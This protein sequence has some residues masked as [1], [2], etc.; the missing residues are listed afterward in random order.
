MSMV[1]ANSHRTQIARALNANN[2][3]GPAGLTV[4]KKR[5]KTDVQIVRR[6]YT[7][8]ESDILIGEIWIRSRR[9]LTGKSRRLVSGRTDKKANLSNGRTHG[10]HISHGEMY[11]IYTRVPTSFL[12]ST[13]AMKAQRSA[14]V[15]RE[16][17]SETRSEKKKLGV[18]KLGVI[19][20]SRSEPSVL[21]RDIVDDGNLE[22][23]LYSR[24]RSVL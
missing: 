19:S 20:L 11:A 23:N 5:E 21:L 24:R 2:I 7:R 4:I 17:S 10:A 3:N 12:S 1:F 13:R 14:R 15:Y 8:R 9:G 16:I 18:R 6:V 22:G